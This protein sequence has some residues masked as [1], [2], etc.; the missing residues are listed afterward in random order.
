MKTILLVDDEKL[1]LSS[2]SE[3]LARLFP[4]ICIITAQNGEEAIKVLSS[5]EVI[6]VITDLQMPVTSGFELL[7]YLMNN[8]PEIGVVV[9]TAFGKPEIEERISAYGS[10][11]YMEKPID[12]QALAEH[13]QEVIAPTAK[14]HIEGIDLTNLLQLLYLERKGCTLTVS[15]KSRKGYLYFVD[16]ELIDAEYDLFQGESATYEILKWTKP[17]IKIESF[18]RKTIR[19]I[20]LPLDYILL[21][22]AKKQDECRRDTGSFPV[23]TFD[24]EDEE[25]KSKSNSNSF[26]QERIQNQKTDVLS[27]LELPEIN[28]SF[29][30]SLSINNIENNI[31]NNIENVLDIEPE[32]SI[33]SDNTTISQKL[34]ENKNDFIDI[35]NHNYLITPEQILNKW[36]KSTLIVVEKSACVFVKYITTQEIVSLQGTDDIERISKEIIDILDIALHCSGMSLQGS[37]EYVNSL[38]GLTIIWD[39][40]KKYIIV[41]TDGFVNNFSVISFRRYKGILERTYLQV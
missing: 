34:L 1:F 38:F 15:S 3:G 36:N 29:L 16:G 5:Q 12:F 18:S 33:Y 27:N 7:A 6:L 14:G 22:A 2:L 21:E 4:Q 28:D 37:F 26:E 9:M 35:S 31:Q 30:V 41:V 39:L 19:K 24:E 40:E 13:V 17:E 20:N 25:D 23:I 8:H 11:V 32:I 10:I